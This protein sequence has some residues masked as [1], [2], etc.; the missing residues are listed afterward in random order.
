MAGA[1]DHLRLIKA[2]IKNTFP[3]LTGAVNVTQAQLNTL[4]TGVTLLSPSG[5]KLRTNDYLS[6]SAVG[7][8]SV[9]AHNGAG[10]AVSV[11]DLFGSG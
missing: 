7:R 10:T 1:D 2:T 8:V 4:A 3:D 6:S 9:F 5:A 11:L